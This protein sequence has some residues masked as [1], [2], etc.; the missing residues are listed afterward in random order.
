MSKKKTR[1]QRAKHR[2]RVGESVI[3][4]RKSR[5]LEP[6]V[7]IVGETP[8]SIVVRFTGTNDGARVWYWAK[9]AKSSTFSHMLYRDARKVFRCGS[10]QQ[11]A[12]NRP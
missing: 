8:I 2:F 1:R 4:H 12:E 7:S 9:Y 11:A 6:A 10:N 5:R 3:V